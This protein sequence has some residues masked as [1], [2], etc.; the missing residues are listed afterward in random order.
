VVHKVPLVGRVTLVVPVEVKVMGLPEPIVVKES[1][2]WTV[3]PAAR[4]KVPEPVEIILPL[5]VAVESKEVEILLAARPRVEIPPGA[6]TAP[7]KPYTWNFADAVDIPP[8][9]KSFEVWI[10]A[11]TPEFNCQKLTVP[12]ALVQL[13]TPPTKVKILPFTPDVVW[14]IKPFDVPYKTPPEVV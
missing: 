11:R 4:V 9:T 14:E 13:G 12:P 5:I 1:A 8:T 2:N 3:L 10:G 7:V 6:L